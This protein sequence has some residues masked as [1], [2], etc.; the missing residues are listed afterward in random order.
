MPANLGGFLAELRKIAA[1]DF[2]EVDEF[3][4]GPLQL[5]EVDPISAKWE[6]VGIESRYFLNNQGTFTFII[7]FKYSLIVFWLLLACCLAPCSRWIRKKKEKLEDSIFWNSWIEVV[8]ESI[9]FVAV[10]IFITISYTESFTESYG[11][12]V[13]TG[14]CLAGIFFYFILPVIVFYRVYSNF[15]QLDSKGMLTTY[16][17]FYKDL[18]YKKHGKKVLAWPVSFLCRRVFMAA[19]VIYAANVSFIY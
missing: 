10:A 16:G 15:D 2:F 17:S 1:F 13:Q 8:F 4:N 19:M 9:I 18:A 5:P 6:S 11:I 3:I 14:F 7:L 12:G